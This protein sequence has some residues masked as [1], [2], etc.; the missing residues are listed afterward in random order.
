MQFRYQ[1][2][3]IVTNRAPTTFRTWDKKLLMK[4]VKMLIL[5]TGDK[6]RDVDRGQVRHVEC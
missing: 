3:K 4:L 1:S 5:D 2:T 6:D